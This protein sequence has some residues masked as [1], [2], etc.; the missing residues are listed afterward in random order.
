MDRFWLSG[1]ERNSFVLDSGG[2]EEGGRLLVKK[3]LLLLRTG[4]M[5]SNENPEYAFSKYIPMM[6]PANTADETLG[7]VCLRWGADGK[8][9]NRLRRSAR[10]SEH[11]S[12]NVEQL[13]AI[14]RLE[15]L[16]GCVNIVEANHFVLFFTG[17]IMWP[18]RLFIQNM[19]HTDC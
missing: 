11:G 1:V 15:T 19:F 13:F 16:H 4:A 5:K 10:I 9:D 17:R 18:L 7:C 14:K 8:A 12:L 6:R 3:I 2:G